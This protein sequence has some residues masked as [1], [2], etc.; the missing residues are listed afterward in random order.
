MLIIAT[1]EDLKWFLEHDIDNCS[2]INFY[3][4]SLQLRGDMYTHTNEWLIVLVV[5]VELYYIEE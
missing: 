3:V 5:F 1:N 4:C 2:L